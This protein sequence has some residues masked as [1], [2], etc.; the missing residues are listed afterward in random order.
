MG[1]S[2]EALAELDSSESEW[3]DEAEPPRPLA[4]P[5]EAI[6][7]ANRAMAWAAATW[8]ACWAAWA[9]E[10]IGTGGGGGYNWN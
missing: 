10:T 6:S 2:G 8:A 9:C 4:L 5:A 7:E 1:V 3:P